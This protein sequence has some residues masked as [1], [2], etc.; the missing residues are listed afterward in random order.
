VSDKREIRVVNQAEY[1]VTH[2]MNANKF[3]AP[4]YNRYSIFSTDF[5]LVDQKA[6]LK[7]VSFDYDITSKQF[8][9]DLD[10]SRIESLIEETQRKNRDDLMIGAPI[11]PAHSSNE[12]DSKYS[13]KVRKA[14]LI[15]L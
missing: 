5:S 12:N 7:K 14:F 9:G 11:D 1:L 10:T 2:N 4:D 8:W 15:K 13:M 6:G 3:S